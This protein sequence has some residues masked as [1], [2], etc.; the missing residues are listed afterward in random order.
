M[1]GAFAPIVG[2]L[3]G[4]SSI[5]V[6]WATLL[7]SVALYI[8]IPVM[9]AQLWR[10]GLLSRGRAHFEAAMERIGP[11]SISALLATEEEIVTGQ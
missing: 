3:L 11:W 7:T 2:L 1:V 10:R 4:I 8:V 9:L 5:H 6:P